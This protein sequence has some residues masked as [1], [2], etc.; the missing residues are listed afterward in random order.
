[1]GMPSAAS[2]LQQLFAQQKLSVIANIGPLSQPLTKSMVENDYS[3][4][5]PQLFSH[6]DQQSLWQSGAMNTAATTG[7]GGRMADLIADT[8]DS[9]S[10]NLSIFGSN[11][12]Q[13]GTIVQP[14]SV[15]ASGPEA[16]AA[17]DPTKDWNAERV[18]VFNRLM[19][20]VSSPLQVA[21][22]NKINSAAANNQRILEALGLVTPTEVDYPAG[23]DLA[24]QLK[25]VASLIAGQPYIGQQRQIFFVGMG[26]WDTHDAQSELHP[27]LLATLG[28]ALLA[29]QQDIEQRSLSQQVTTFTL[30][31]FG[32][33]LTS[34]GDGTDH[35]WGGHQLVMGGAIK[36]GDVMG[37]LPSL[38]LDSNDDIGGGRMLPTLSI[39]QYGASL[40]EWFGLSNNEIAAVFPNFSRFDNSALQLFEG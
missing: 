37:I 29:F 6:N 15:D 11:L 33:T 22:A 5:P 34:N 14:F 19:A 26:G 31:E 32:R 17:L 36:G 7:W 20:E 39:D 21:Y 23:N 4:L 16:F 30:S 9:L 3:L 25:M 24:S 38:E 28:D 13:A 8:N 40:S 12:M 18:D 1:M 2:S 27:Q 35:G 10:M